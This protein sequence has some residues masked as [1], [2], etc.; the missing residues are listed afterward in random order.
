[1]ESLLRSSA[2]KVEAVPSAERMDDQWNHV[3]EH[4]AHPRDDDSI[5]QDG[6]RERKPW[7][8]HAGEKLYRRKHDDEG[9]RDG[10]ATPGF[11]R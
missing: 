8:D 6:G 11:R 7:C 1:M 4:E 3:S 9:R 5:A 2:Q 10:L